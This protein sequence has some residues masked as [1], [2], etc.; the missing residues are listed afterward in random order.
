VSSLGAKQALVEAE[1][2]AVRRQLAQQQ[3]HLGS[4]ST[5]HSILVAA[6]RSG[7]P[8]ASQSS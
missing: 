5:L 6:E 4:G 3:E 8:M 2:F 1:L 7:F